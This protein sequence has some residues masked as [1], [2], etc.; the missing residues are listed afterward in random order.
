MKVTMVFV[1]AIAILLAAGSVMAEVIQLPRTGQ[2][3][4]YSGSSETPCEGTGQDGEEQRGV[5]W[6][7]PRS[8]LIYCN[9]EGP[10]PN[11]DEDCDA[12]SAN[13]VITDHLTGLMW[14]TCSYYSPKYT[15]EGAVDRGQSQSVCGYADWRVPNVVEFLSVSSY[16]EKARPPVGCGDTWTSTTYAGD[17]TKAW[18]ASTSGGAVTPYADVKTA[19]YASLLVRSAEIGTIA[20]PRSGQSVSY[21]AGDDGALRKGVVWPDPRFTDNK[22]FTVTDNL[23]GI[24]WYKVYGGGWWGDALNIVKRRNENKIYCQDT[25]RLPN[26]VELRSLFDFGEYNPA[27]PD[28]Q[29]FELPSEYGTHFFWSS[30][31]LS[32]YASSA[33]AVKRRDG[34]PTTWSKGV[35]DGS[36]NLTFVGGPLCVKTLTVT[37]TGAGSGSVKSDPYGIDCGAKCSQPYQDGTVI[38][39]TATAEYGSAFYGWSG[40]GCS[41]VGTCVVKLTNHTTVTAR[42]LPIRTLTVSKTGNG[43]G[44]VTS[45]PAGI[46]CGTDCSF[47]YVQGVVVTLTATPAA[48]SAF[49]GWSGGGC[50]GTGTCTIAMTTDTT[51]VPTF[52][53]NPCNYT[54][55]PT[56]G[57]FAAK[58]G[59]AKVAVTAQG[60][61]TCGEPG[62]AV[63]DPWIRAAVASFANNHGSVNV[64]V[65]E[66]A[67][68]AKRSGTATIGGKPFKVTQAGA[69]S[70]VL[71]AKIQGDGTVAAAGLTCKGTTCTGDYLS[72]TTVSLTATPKAGGGFI[73]WTGCKTVS[74]T[75][76]QV[77]MTS[78]KTV[79]ATFNDLNC[80]YTVAPPSKTFSS[81]GGSFTIA[82]TGVGGRELSR[83]GYLPLRSLDRGNPPLF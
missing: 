64:T 75:T 8:T 2:T 52:N 21:R 81:G 22:D 35:Q 18:Y 77:A 24:R 10:C 47:K 74:G 68:V 28:P 14:T 67:T 69:P 5:A 1:Y 33:F 59:S 79:T 76:C 36:L 83:S 43:S 65:L 27:L 63:S 56:A 7:E 82:V 60:A 31:T 50:T 17:F 54:V 32:T 51:V 58:G 62:L 39:L 71:T 4:C 66:N 19:K 78:N 49:A 42:F 30:T 9:S 26:I 45:D 25:W 72:N 80:K 11:Q 55:T 20:L 23:T 12:N 38:T 29:P 6:P 41:G 48:G 57:S 37:K 40:G 70:Y 53:S 34:E 73:S 13:D 16:S 15:W 44:K 46:N 3:K 61:K